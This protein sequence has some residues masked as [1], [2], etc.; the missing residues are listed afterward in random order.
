MDEESGRLQA[1]KS[2]RGP[3]VERGREG[4]GDVAA[5]ETSDDIDDANRLMGR[6]SGAL[7][8]K[9]GRRETGAERE[10]AV[11]VATAANEVEKTLSRPWPACVG[12]GDKPTEEQLGEAISN[13]PD[14]AGDWAVIEAEE[15]LVL[16]RSLSRRQVLSEVQPE[17]KLLV[18]LEPTFP[19]L[20]TVAS[21]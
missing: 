13:L 1:G 11:A 8:E 16:R 4:E 3:H 15:K 17:S 18:A 14:G 9:D 6:K 19:I 10:P 5:S 20:A 21:V 2:I 12:T 7:V